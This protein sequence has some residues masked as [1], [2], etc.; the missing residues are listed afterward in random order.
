M[1][2]NLNDI[3]V[4][5]VAMFAT[6]TSWLGV[7]A[8]PVYIL[9]ATN[10]IDYATGVMAAPY[11]G[12]VKSSYKGALGIKKKI[13]M[14]LLVFV[15]F[16]LDNLIS[17]S[18]NTIGITIPFTYLIACITALWLCSNEIISILENISD[19]LGD[20]MPNFLLKITKNIRSQVE[21]KINS[22]EEN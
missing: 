9:V 7:L 10:I 6:L 13:S 19:I 1:Q 12:E 14:W 16:M 8:I 20:S 22:K 3:K 4:F 5:T 2:E 18:S 17:Y 15:G 21:E 11:R